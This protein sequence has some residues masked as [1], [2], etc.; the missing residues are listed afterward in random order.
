MKAQAVEV[1]VIGDGCAALSLAARASEL[2]HHTLTVYRP[3][4]APTR[5][6]HIWAFWSDPYVETAESLALAQWE[7]WRVVTDSGH[8]TQVSTSRPYNAMRRSAWMNRCR[9]KARTAGVVFENLSEADA[10]EKAVLFDSRPSAVPPGVML[11]HFLGQEVRTPHAAFEP[12]VAT[13]M[14]FRVEQSCGMHFVYVLP[15]SEN[16]ALVESTVFST[17]TLDEGFYIRAIQQYLETHR[18]VREYEVCHQERGV[19]PLGVLPPHQQGIAGI[20][21]N[22]GAIRPA[23]GYAFPFIQRQIDQGI[24]SSTESS[25]VFRNPHRTLDLWMDAVMLQVLRVE[26]ER[27]PEIFLRMANTLSGD[28]MAAFLSGYA[29]WSVRV[30]LILSLPKWPFLKAAWRLMIRNGFSSV[31]GVQWWI[32]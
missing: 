31:K 4:N 15:F 17:A 20:G 24:E 19:I 11:Q 14:D 21:G 10:A 26:P 32:S 7:S 16:H 27:G 9:E 25:L 1:G 3:P 12:G 28:E 2:T 29:T 6:D 13:L 8:A 18:G 23:S 22:G 5:G 30:K